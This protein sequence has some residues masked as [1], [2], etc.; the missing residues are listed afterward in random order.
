[1]AVQSGSTGRAAWSTGQTGP[2]DGALAGDPGASLEREEDTEG[3]RLV[4]SQ[5]ASEGTL[6]LGAFVHLCCCKQ[7][8]RDWVLHKAQKSSLA[9]L[10]AEVQ[11]QGTCR[12]G[13]W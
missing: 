4:L 9:V 3:S 5:P 2:C 11:D 12:L 7:K 10:E 8:T 13:V 1:M 6:T